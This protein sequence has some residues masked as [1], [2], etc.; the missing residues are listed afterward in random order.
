M[1]VGQALGKED[2]AAASPGVCPRPL[3]HDEQLLQSH[4]SDMNQHAAEAPSGEITRHHECH[5][6]RAIGAAARNRME[7]C[8]NREARRQHHRDRHHG[9]APDEEEQG[10]YRRHVA[11]RAV[12]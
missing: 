2:R 11:A 3:T 10:K 7:S 12:M 8:Q 9:P 6:Q 5:Q 4:L 1:R